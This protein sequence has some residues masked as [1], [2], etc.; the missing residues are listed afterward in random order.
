VTAAAQRKQRLKAS[1]RAVRVDRFFSLHL[2]HLKGQ[3]AGQPFVL[4]PWQRDEIVYP[5]FGSVDPR[6]YRT[7]R[8]ALVG[9]ARG[10][11]KSPF[12][13]GIG[14]YGTFADDEPGAE[15][16]A[17]AASKDQARVVFG[18]AAAMVRAS[19]MLD[20]M[21]R[22]Y[23]DVIEVPETGSIFRVLAADAGLAHGLI[24]HIC[25]IDELHVHKNPDLY[26]AIQSALHK[27]RHPL[28]FGMSTAGFDRTTLLW[29]LFERGLAGDDPRFFFR[30]WAGPDGCAASDTK[31]M[32]AAN[33]ASWITIRS[34]QAQR[35]SMP[36]A[37][38]RRLHLNQWTTSE[39]T[40]IPMP[41][42]DACAGKPSIPVDAPV[43]IGVDAAPKKD[44]TAVV[45]V[46]RDD[47]GVHHW[48]VHIFRAD[49]AMGYLDFL[50][51]E[52][53]LRELCMTY[54]VRR[55]LFDPFT[56]MRSMIT[57]AE[58]GLPVE[59]YP[60]NDAR[61]VPAS[62]TLYDLVLEA[63][64]RHGGDPVLRAQAA[65]AAARETSRGWRLQKLR[66]AS[67]IDSIVAGAMASHIAEQ[68]ATLSG[69]STVFSFDEDEL[70]DLDD[71]E[72]NLDDPDLDG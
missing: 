61:M 6:G 5:L 3:F 17:L 68:E 44:T 41:L 10:D 37:I 14:L 60:Q 65:V 53:L 13:A 66:S 21:A 18:T 32:R 35:R 23:R 31:A 20:A 27:R 4:E 11:G 57:L 26:E 1:A 29:R 40:W 30:W 54:D 12:G 28:L 64:V 9:V 50:E 16:Y 8:E 71:D 19:P 46:Y 45:I 69:G 25:T 15:C 49:R 59:E 48:K 58:E 51:V 42:W 47:H 63:R 72:L 39:A 22:V 56:M 67:A 7:Y 36:E 38:F 24:P 2:R 70:D 52:D 33:P 62:Q 34:L 43:F 55:I